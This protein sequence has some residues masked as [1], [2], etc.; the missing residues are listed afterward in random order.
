MRRASSRVILVAAAATAASALLQSSANAAVSWTGTGGVN[1]ATGSSWS[2]GSGPSTAD[3]VNFTDVGSTN[4]PNEVT[5]LLNISRTIGGLS[6]NNSAGKFHTLDLG[7]N[8]LTVAGN[9]NFNLDQNANTTTTIRNGSI[10]INSAFATVGFGRGVSGSSSAIA[11]LSGVSSFA[12]NTQNF[13]VGS[14]TGGAAAGVLTLGPTNSITANLIQVGAFKGSSGTLHLGSGTNTIQAVQWDIAKDDA[15][16]TVDVVNGGSVSIGTAT[17]RT[18]L[19]IANQ[20]TNTIP[21]HFGTLNL[22]NAAVDLHFDSLLVAQKSGGSGAIFGTLNGGGSGSAFIGDAAARGDITIG[23]TIFGGSCNGTVDFSRLSTMQAFVNDVK[24]GTGGGSTGTFSLAANS[25][26]DASNS[27]VVGSG[28]N[29]TLTAGTGTSTLLAN[30]ITVGKDYSDSI[31]RAP[32]GSTLTLGSPSR[33]VSLSLAN[34]VANSN[35]TYTAK[36]DATGATLNAYLSGL[37]VGQRTSGGGGGVSTGMI[38]GATGGTVD[39]GTPGTNTANVI[40]GT[41]AA[42]VGPA[43]GNV[44]FG[45]LA[46]FTASLNTLSIGTTTNQSGVAGTLILGAN[47]TINA[48]SII[49]GSNGDG[50]D[51]LTLGRTNTIVTNQF[52]IGKDYATG[53]VTLPAN[54]TLNLGSPALRTNITMGVGNTNTLNTYAGTLDCSAGTLVAYLDQVVIGDKNALSGGET[55]TLSISSRP[56][57]RVEANSIALGGT[58]STGTINF[59][60]GQFFAGSITGGAGTANFNWTGGQLSVATFGSPTRAFNLSNTGTGQLSPGSATAAIGMTQVYGNYTQGSAG[61]TAMEIAGVS[62]GTGNDLL[63]VSGS[64]TLAGNLNLSFANGFVP[65]AGQNLLLATYASRTGTYG[66]VAPPSMP[67]NVAFQ[68][69]YTTTPTQLMMRMVVPTA[70]NYTSTAAQGT[71]STGANWSGGTAPVTSTAATIANNTANPQ[72]VTVASSATVH[73]VT[74]QGNAAPLNLEVLQGVRF[75]VANQLE[76]GNNATLSGGGQVLGNVSVLAGGSVAPGPG[77]ATL[78]VAG[79]YGQASSGRLAIEVGGSPSGSGFDTVN[80]SGAAALGGAITLSNVNGF[81][82]AKTDV[83]PVLTYAAH[84]GHFDSLALTASA[85]GQSYSVHYGA[86]Q[87]SVLSGEWNSPADIG[88]EFDVPGGLLVSGDWNW[89]GLLIKRGSGTLTLNLDEDFTTGPGSSLAIV[90]GTFRLGAGGDTALVL[91]GLSF[92]DLGQLSGD[93]ELYGISGFYYSSVSAVPEPATMTALLLVPL[94]ASLRRR[95]H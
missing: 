23:N 85:P 20:N 25:S 63:S 29:A 48:N 43:G 42:G 88:G 15:D 31:L 46:S 70:Q 47:N 80:V 90:D 76:V 12:S 89:S 5:S 40:I 41:N 64:A 22:G 69:D 95:C 33:R 77:A 84:T 50:V 38:F 58:G 26:I 7:T 66:F 79:N 28:A 18:A 72:T 4:Q 67:Q 44:D 2:N 27:I 9:F 36:I 37:T 54:G 61:T 78:A 59:A 30:E 49:V 19:Q 21:T 32:A 45:G 93:P 8:T 10:S 16:A 24:I 92:G 57:N 74:L 51:K 11:D 14:S 71:W 39:I 94:M 68:L 83:F 81:T 62:P 56:G 86:S 3:T 87:V 55:G 34:S 53:I 6:F 35:Q 75:G 60:G 13:Y 91:S 82:P 73:R 52:T 17:Q 65:S 1:W